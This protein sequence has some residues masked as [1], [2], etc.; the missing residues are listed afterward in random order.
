MIIQCD[1]DGTIS[2]QDTCVPIL[3]QFADGDWELYDDLLIKLYYVLFTNLC[4][5]GNNIL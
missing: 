2:L 4:I 3:E 1:F 5:S